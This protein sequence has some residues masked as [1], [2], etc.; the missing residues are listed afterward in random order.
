MIINNRFPVSK[1]KLVS[2]KNYNNRKNRFMQFK[3]I[4]IVF[5]L[6]TIV[7][8][9]GADSQN[10]PT[11][12]P[13]PNPTSTIPLPTAT[14]PKIVAFDYVQKAKNK[15][16]KA[17][18]VQSASFSNA[19]GVFRLPLADQSLTGNVTISVDLEDPDGI[20]NVYVG[21][22]G[23]TKALE[24]CATDCGVAY[25]R[26]VTGINPLDYGQSSGPQQL[27]LWVQD[28]QGNKTFL[29][30]V[31]FI[32][33]KTV[34][35][36]LNAERT[37]GNI[38]LSWNALNNYLR[39]NVYIASQA[40]VT[41][42][43][44]QTLA[45][46]QAFLA[47][48]DPQKVLSG[49]EDA[50]AFFTAVTAI[51]GSGES[52]FSETLKVSALSGAE[53]FAPTAGND[54]YF[55]DEDTTL[56]ENV[57]TNDSDLESQ[58]LT[59]STAPIRQ[60]EN[61]T[62]TINAD[63]TINYIPTAD[64][65]GRDN[66]SYRISDG[67]GQTAEA[68]VIITVN[69]VNDPPEASFNNF[70]L[71]DQA[72]GK[73][74]NAPV[75]L[76]NSHTLARAQ[77]Q[78]LL[79][80]A[81]P[82]L[83]INDLDIDGNSIS[84]VTT[85]VV[86]PTQGTVTLNAD[87][88]FE[89]TNNPG[90]SGEDSFSYH[91]TDGTT[92]SDPPT[93]V[94][95]TING[96]SFFPVAANDHYT[97]IE[98]QTFVADNSAVGRMSILNNDSD[99]DTGDELSIITNF[100]RSVA[101]GT[102]NMGADGTF[103]YIP[104]PGY[105]G[106]DS[107]IYQITDLQGNTAQ[108]GG[109][110]TI[111]RSNEVP[112]AITDDYALTED[113]LFSA[114]TANGLLGNDSD[115]DL[116]PITVDSTPAQAP[117]N[118]QLTLETDGSFVYIPNANFAG[119]DSFSYLVSDDRGG[120][121]T[122]TVTLTIINVN[123]I[124]I[125]NDDT[126]Q[127]I[128]NTPITINVLSNDSDIENQAL[129]VTNAIVTAGTV[130][131]NVDNTL[132]YTPTTG[133]LGK[134]E[135][136]YAITD[137]AGGN[138]TAK[139]FVSVDNVNLAPVA[140]NDDYALNEDQA[141]NVNGNN[142]PLLTANDTDPNGDTLT[143]N[144][145]AQTNPA[146]GSVTLAADGTFSYQPNANFFGSD[147]FTYQ[148]LDG[149]GGSATATVDLT[150][151]SVNDAPLA[152]PDSIA[153]SEETLINI[154]PLRNDSDVENDTLTL[155]NAVTNNGTAT[156]QSNNT[157]NY[158]PVMNF[159]GVAQVS[160]LVSDNNGGTATGIISVTV[161]NIN[162]APVALD[163]TAN[164]QENTAVNINVLANDSDIDG[165]TLVV[166]NA[167]VS[168]PT[169]GTVSANA[170]NSLLFTPTT[171]FNGNASVNYTISDNNGGIAS[172]TVTVNVISV[173][174]TP[175]AVNDY[176]TT[177]EDTLVTINVLA[178][179]SDVDGDALMVTDPTA[180]NGT[181]SVS[182]DSSLDYLPN[183]NFNGSDTISYNVND[184]NGATDSATVT[185]TITAVND[186]PIGVADTA[187]TNE[188]N[189][190]NIIV[191]A[192]DTDIDTNATALTVTAVSATN[193]TT[194]VLP[195]QTIDYNPTLNFNG[196][197]TISYT[198]NDDLG[199]SSSTTVSLTIVAQNDAPVAVDDTSSTDEDTLVAINVLANDSDIDGD[200]L[201]IDAAQA[202][203]GTVTVNADNSLS[204]TPISNFNGAD[205]ISYT[206]IDV[207]GLTVSASVAVTVNPVNDSPIALSSTATTTE[208]VA[209]SIV[210]LANDSDIDG[211]ALT[212]STASANNGSVTVNSVDQSLNYSPKA[213][214]N[215]EDTI[216]YSIDDGNG[217]SA[218]ASVLVTVLVVND[219][220]V[221]S[222]TPATE[223]AE[224]AGYSFTPTVSDIDAMDTATFKI[225]NQ[226]SWASF[227]TATG[228]L[229]GSP[230][231][232]NVGTTSDI[233]ITVSDSADAQAS[234][235]AFSIT[236][237]N[238]N[239]AP[240]AVAD[241]YSVDEGNTLN[242]NATASVLNNDSDIDADSVITT[243]LV[244]NV[245][246]GT[247]TLNLDGSFD[248]IHD[249]SETI[250][251]SF[252]YKANDTFLDS[253][254]VTV[255]LTI[256]PKNDAPQ[257]N[258]DVVIVD[259]DATVPID[260]LANDFDSE[261]FLLPSST[262]VVTAP[263]NGATSIN[264]NNGVITYTPSVNFNGPDSFTYQVSD[265]QDG[266]SNIATVSI[267]VESVND[268]P[269]MV[270]DIQ[271]INEDVA[272]LIDILANDTDVDTD[273][274]VSTIS[275]DTQPSNGRVTI[276]DDKVRYEPTSDFN[277]TDNFTYHAQDSTGT[278]GN[279]ATVT[280]NITGE[281][282]LPFAVND[283]ANTDEDTPVTID[284][285]VNDSDVDGEDD[286]DRATVSMMSAPA[287]GSLSI[288]SDNGAITY[289]P[290]A[291]IN[292][293]DSFT[294]VVKD[295]DDGTSNEATVNITINPINDAP[296]ANNDIVSN[297][298]EDIT[299]PIN[300]LGN[301]SDIENGI[302][303]ATV[304]IA[305]APGQGTVSVDPATGVISYTPGTNYFG[306]DS[307][308]YSVS[309][310]E[311]GS[312]N[313]ATVTIT[314]SNV[315]DAPTI[316]S[317][318]I[319]TVEED[320]LYEYQ[321]TASDIDNGDSLTIN[322]STPLPSWLIL[323]DN[324]D[325]SANL[326]GTP[327]ND[328]V[329][330]YDI[331][332][333][334]TD[335]SGASDTQAFTL[336]VINVNDVPIINSSVISTV[337]EDT[338]YEYQ[339]AASDIDNGD[340]L[341]ISSSTPLPSWLI[342]SDNGD[343]SASLMGTPDNNAVGEYDINLTVTD[344]SSASD[345]QAFTLTVINVND[346]P[347]AENDNATATEDTQL[348][349]TVLNNDSDPDGDTLTVA[350]VSANNGTV[351]V[352]SADQS[353]NYSPNANF[354]G[355][356][357]INYTIS[358]GNGGT[359]TALVMV[360][361][362]GINDAP[363]ANDDNASVNEDSNINISVLENDNDVDGDTLTITAATAT[364][365]AVTIDNG[366]SLTYT[367]NANFSG[368]DTVSYTISDGQG[369]SASSSVSVTISSVN[370]IPIANADIASTNEDTSVNI[371]V[372]ANDIDVDGD[373]LTITAA[374]AT[375]GAVTIDN[376]I[377]LTYTPNAN[378]NG[379]DTIDYT[380]S[381]DNGGTAT[382]IVTVSVVSVN[383]APTYTDGI[384]S[385]A[386]NVAN[387][388]TVL[389]ISA[390]DIDGDNLTYS[391]QSGN[392]DG[393]FAI[394]PN[395]GDVIIADNLL[396]NYE[397]AT[398]HVVTFKVTDDGVGS[399]SATAT[400][401]IT[402]T[403]VEENV[404][405]TLDTA[406]GTSGTAG[407][408]AFAAGRF[409]LPKA[410]VIDA[411]GK[412]V[413]V[414][415]NNYSGPLTEFFITRFNTDG[416]LDRSFGH[417]GLVTE[418]FGFQVQQMEAIGVTIDSF[419]NIIIIGNII[420]IA[421]DSRNLVFTARYTHA[422]VLDTTF[423]SGFGYHYYSEI[424]VET[425]A[426]DAVLDADNNILIAGHNTLGDFSLIK[427]SADGNTHVDTT[428]DFFNGTDIAHA[429]V[430]QSDGKALIVGT[431]REP[432]CQ[433]GSTLDDFGIAR[434]DVSSTPFLDTSYNA[435]GMA[436]FDF[437]NSQDDSAF[438]AYINNA[439]EVVM[440]GASVHPTGNQTDFA[441]LKIDSSGT[442][443]TGF[444]TNGL[445]VVDIDGDGTGTSN[446]STGTTV[447]SDSSNNLY[448]GIYTG[449]S[450]FDTV[451]Y[452]T[453][454][455]GSVDNTYGTSG[456]ATFGLSDQEN[457]AQDL[458]IDSSNRAVLLTTT[459]T[460]VEPD[461]VVAR[462]TSAGILDSSFSVDG[463]NTLD[464]TF[465]V[466]TLSE[467]IELSVAP[468]AGKFVAVGTTVGSSGSVLIVARYNADG[469]QDETF[470]INGYY[471][472]VSVESNIVGQD[473]V[474][475]SDGKLVVV[476]SF[477]EQG[478]VVM[479]KTDGTLE[480]SF[481]ETSFNHQGSKLLSSGSQLSFNAVAVDSNNKIVVAG[482]DGYDIYIARMS[483]SGTLDSNFGD[484]GEFKSDLN[485]NETV[486]DIAIQ[487][488]NAIVAVGQKDNNGLV[489]RVLDN[490]TLDTENFA[491]PNNG[492]ATI[493]L[494][495]EING[496]VHTLRRIKIKS[497]GK[498]V[499]AG[500]YT[501]EAQPASLL[502]QLNS[503][504]IV[505]TS[506][507]YGESEAKALGLA[508]DA[509]GRILITGFNSNDTNQDIFIARIEATGVLDQMFNGTGGILFD[510]SSSSESAQ[511]ILVRDDG[512]IVIAGADKLNLFP[513]SFFFIQK[514]ILVEP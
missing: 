501:I 380:M 5:L 384:A 214:F 377:S 236:V 207:G 276:V 87:G 361:V 422:G 154:N 472:H 347:I 481:N 133:F 457:T 334:V 416:T 298:V 315:N 257:A 209:I 363:V 345:S 404:T 400:G 118:G 199:G 225:V 317:S 101:H 302:N 63:G 64:F 91:I 261:D 239:D 244:N 90:S 514:F 15:A 449:I 348:V 30:N 439:D 156:V 312:S 228:A 99:L 233:V 405:P 19:T 490:G 43:N 342:L 364:S 478:L 150:I 448:F 492:Y 173:N 428:L 240:V 322:S 280:I 61:G 71:I 47:L 167:T 176:A 340:S 164:T 301:D 14:A 76:S 305:S 453:D 274:K 269:V 104:T 307:F 108:A 273:D 292:G 418:D 443:I 169:N 41:H 513:T 73:N 323:S 178:N 182:L 21:F 174:S 283:S 95:I 267:N 145:T 373:T 258:D 136:D 425:T 450:N 58:T 479:L 399:L 424:T 281:N 497:D 142:L 237:S 426:T 219:A 487:S 195:N 456:Q 500:N 249:G 494:D 282:D 140:A 6:S 378:F 320:A 259:E 171:N 371:D 197:D 120:V 433:E 77:A 498:I 408:N 123:D 476:G 183:A 296:V 387:N 336:T 423:H 285:L 172:A 412:L 117:I 464:A 83:L 127:T 360:T 511:A 115:V 205:T 354:N 420:F 203:S 211:D 319:S 191:L 341:T 166:L 134:A 491:S 57:L 165:D 232:K 53:D 187:V 82:G 286:I 151:A 458:Q 243:V 235:A 254:A 454:A 328:A 271:T 366:I 51:D 177:D 401:T 155:I 430:L 352:N 66:F 32:W 70:N 92:V 440:T 467:L 231:N 103:T 88:S 9:C 10:Q 223:V 446:Q 403:N 138:T 413:V 40:G 429:I 1:F 216:N 170:D 382:A 343:G 119:S 202:N 295:T 188:D 162:D 248:Y 2:T 201:S 161:L 112:I 438:D 484:S 97:L 279:T 79:A 27:Q 247:L 24:L 49:K 329:G 386:E 434:F 417:Q 229:T 18:Q 116:D 206:L 309:D 181:V 383:D 250:T 81:A 485:A 184:G 406:F 220:P 86:E 411:S 482:T 435:T 153:T 338:L 110:F 486:E 294:Y 447:A 303:S 278:I 483:V 16:Y 159:V 504:G 158:T 160:Y 379:S 44:Y 410:S 402:V 260:V 388:T 157:L 390:A 31:S 463:F 238:T 68:V 469:S 381:D 470:G 65:V 78:A 255:T 54:N 503:D 462:Y 85:P 512:S 505:T 4:V 455:N 468:H 180:T 395:T 441:S 67:L 445:L 321:V 488:N 272:I 80:V 385:I 333:T 100:V 325:G 474:E 12:E 179:D 339:V 268:A 330:E 300:V 217:G 128:L 218:S 358:D 148:I 126:V 222:G 353:L 212:V 310:N 270:N 409:D 190:I 293:E 129:T 28:T 304:S 130:A 442:L 34:V 473:I 331:N 251:D 69:Q 224:D 291:N 84:V 344:D 372:L 396:L 114:D 289:T 407:S 227:D 349:F 477:D 139:V 113:S 192:N 362:N 356:D 508:L 370:D 194:T 149:R 39:Y 175:V 109:T 3:R 368:T 324:G 189:A 125:A 266:T 471:V 284:V 314:V 33:N 375:S 102:L 200:T 75:G 22:A 124:P 263:S 365:G 38:E 20:N 245:N 204:Y 89:Y 146:N 141:L 326:V 105:Y 290:N 394:E 106:T 510:Y 230:E 37:V 509:S 143:V 46:G 35:T 152:N 7:S 147:S 72:R 275:I 466:D 221:I 335:G 42:E 234:L 398:E 60:P 107:F 168:N 213:N 389:S 357:T 45:D 397:L 253:N 246:N 297:V 193:G 55:M 332:L 465:S 419:G 185:V 436:S 392:T 59:I 452:K 277:G 215:G 489:F 50:K 98:N 74:H 499:T 299:Y 252:T 241:A 25:R 427:F 122:G 493:D 313:P 121:S 506:Y 316:D 475:L 369:A 48:R 337:E 432:A 502:V 437:G 111:T 308:T 393:I 262:S 507:T 265:S 198:V 144:T 52:A 444:G 8:A 415:R 131:I 376:G 11:L 36:G 264:T 495:S 351:T 288:D 461:V 186:A 346:A 163:D 135:I 94:R 196:V 451:I 318:A 496:D 132:T 29:T 414:G 391:I 256:N 355:S 287:K 56:I 137:G 13:T 210:V 226:P 374:T 242:V 459:T 26:T 421:N 62:L 17:T 350:T 93:V 480:T 311:G 96:A 306:N 327:D 431:V 208:D 367:P 460:V 359:A 23:G